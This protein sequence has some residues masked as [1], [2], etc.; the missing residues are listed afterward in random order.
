[1]KPIVLSVNPWYYCNFRCSF[2]YL[3]DQ[4]LSDKKLLPLERLAEMVDEVLA[5]GHLIE[6]IDIYGGEVLLLPEAYLNGMKAVFH[7]RGIEDLCLITNLSLV[8]DFAQD[9]DFELSVSYDFG[10]REKSE[11]VFDNMLTLTRRF[12]I[13]TLAGRKFLDAV[14]VDEYVHTLNLLSNLWCVEIKPYSEN[15]ANADAVSFKEFE[16]FVWEVLNHPDRQFYFENETLI[17]KAAELKTRNA[18]S[19]NHVYITPEGRY[20]VLEFDSQDREYFLQLDSFVA[21]AAWCEVEKERVN[22]NSF[23]SA[24]EFK[25]GCLSEHLRDVKSMENSCNGF[26]GLLLRWVDEGSPTQAETRDHP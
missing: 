7:E 19:D 2:C 23:C 4:Q 17:R 11:Q 20:A 24:C 22:A 26:H 14:S 21:Y 25:G 10:A 1:M 5:A 12:N 15:Q 16:D 9:P 8:N 6:H 18:F 13:L 3:T